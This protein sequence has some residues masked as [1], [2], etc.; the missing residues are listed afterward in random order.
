MCVS[1][2]STSLRFS[3]TSTSKS[4]RCNVG[5]CDIDGSSTVSTK[6]NILFIRHCAFDSSTISLM[7][8]LES[9]KNR[10]YR[11]WVQDFLSFKSAYDLM[12]YVHAHYFGNTGSSWILNSDIESLSILPGNI[13]Y[14]NLTKTARPFTTTAFHLGVISS[15]L[16]GCGKL[17][18]WELVKVMQ[19]PQYEDRSLPN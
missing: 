18:N 2:S 9:T 5:S 11:Q 6:L 4:T 16:S 15:T 19:M 13:C 1:A 7:E 10:L 17:Q 14:H 12:Y 3:I 8:L